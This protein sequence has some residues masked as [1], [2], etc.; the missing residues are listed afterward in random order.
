MKIF[1]TL[2]VLLILVFA[3]S[4]EKDSAISE[5]G[6]NFKKDLVKAPCTID[7]PDCGN[8]FSIVTFT[9]SSDTHNQNINWSVVSG[10]MS[11]VSGQGTTSA[12]FTLNSSFSGGSVNV[13]AGTCSLTKQILKCTP[14]PPSCGLT[15]SNVNELNALGDDEVAFY[16]VPNLSSGW[17][18]TSS[19]FEVTRD[20]GFKTTHT[21]YLN[22]FGYP[23]IIITVPCSPQSGRVDKVKVTVTAQSSS[24]DSCTKSV[25]T[26]F[27]SVC[28]T[29]G[30]GF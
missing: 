21:G 19:V 3:A 27:L 6:L 4:C 24:G 26:D 1:K 20:S 18:I 16:T 28:G 25:T 8:P 15:I 5:E 11:L 17:S 7:G 13:T 10:N 29:G 22:N 14:P 23:Q 2:F 9:Y 12:T 30:F